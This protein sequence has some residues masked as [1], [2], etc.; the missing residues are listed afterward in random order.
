MIKPGRDPSPWRAVVVGLTAAFTLAVGGCGSSGSSS[1]EASSSD[2]TAVVNVY[3][4]ALVAGDGSKAC[5]LFTPEEKDKVDSL[6]GSCEQAINGLGAE[7]NVAR[8]KIEVSPAKI[9]GDRAT[10]VMSAGAQRTTFT[11]EQAG[12]TWK[13]ASEGG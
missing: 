2:P 10:V 7:L 4:D 6:T 8:E 13:I 12:D 1:S 3:V 5:S 11:L 9:H